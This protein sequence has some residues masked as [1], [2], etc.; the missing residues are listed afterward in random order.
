MVWWVT[1]WTWYTYLTSYHK[2]VVGHGLCLRKEVRPMT[3]IVI[4]V[5]VIKGCAALVTLGLGIRKICLLIKRYRRQKKKT[6][7]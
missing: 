3:T 6:T 4:V 2:V 7:V 5:N 1:G